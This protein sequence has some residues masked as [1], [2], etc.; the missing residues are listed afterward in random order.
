MTFD[1]IPSDLYFPNSTVWYPF[2]TLC[3]LCISELILFSPFSLLYLR[4]AVSCLSGHLYLILTPLSP[5]FV[6]VINLPLHILN[7]YYMSSF[8]GFPSHACVGE[9]S[10]FSRLT[11]KE[12]IF[13]WNLF[14]FLGV[15]GIS[16][17]LRLSVCLSI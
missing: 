14:F 6:L 5:T 8:A 11:Q 9:C 13:I 7:A 15:Q 16:F 12:V 4:S 1:L 3:Y 2:I 10:F 17:F